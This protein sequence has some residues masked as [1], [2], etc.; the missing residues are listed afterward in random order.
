M[1]LTSSYVLTLSGDR[2]GESEVVKARLN[3][4]VALR[5]APVTVYGTAGTRPTK[6]VQPVPITDLSTMVPPADTHESLQ[7]APVCASATSTTP[8]P[9]VRANAS[10]PVMSED[11]ERDSRRYELDVEDAQRSLLGLWR[12]YAFVCSAFAIIAIT[13][14]VRNPVPMTR[15]GMYMTYAMLSILALASTVSLSLF[16][17]AKLCALR[18]RTI[19]ALYNARL[20]RVPFYCFRTSMVA[21]Y[22]YNI[23]GRLCKQPPEPEPVTLGELVFFVLYTAMLGTVFKFEGAPV[24]IGTEDE[25]GVRCMRVDKGEESLQESGDGS[26][27]V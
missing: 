20:T 11:N 18:S 23:V 24:T 14:E 17:H 12:M 22:V 27:I 2:C 10:S 3:E 1:S 9:P 6:P 5:S 15:F 21:L 26:A 7:P 19:Y 13:V 25:L 8:V 4:M 16:M